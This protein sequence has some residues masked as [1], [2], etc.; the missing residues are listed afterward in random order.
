MSYGSFVTDWK[1]AE[2][3]NPNF[4]CPK[5]T[6]R[7]ISFREWESRD[8]AHEDLKYRC[9]TCGHIWWVDRAKPKAAPTPSPSDIEKF[10]DTAKQLAEDYEPSGIIVKATPSPSDEER[11]QLRGALSQAKAD[12]QTVTAELS[13]VRKAVEGRLATK[14]RD[15]AEKIAKLAEQ[16]AEGNEHEAEVQ[17]ILKDFAQAI[18]DGWGSP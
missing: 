18:R 17:T 11:L 14:G 2:S 1:D 6:E 5:C 16:L 12:L 3:A 13:E 10:V 7:K 9:E 15:T 4:K 8:G